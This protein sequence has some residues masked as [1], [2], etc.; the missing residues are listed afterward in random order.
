MLCC[1]MF[2]GS[3]PF[4][5][6]FCDI[7]LALFYSCLKGI[8]LQTL[9][10]KAIPKEKCRFLRWTGC[11]VFVLRNCLFAKSLVYSRELPLFGTEVFSLYSTCTGLASFS[12]TFVYSFQSAE[13]NERE[14]KCTLTFIEC[15]Q[16]SPYLHRV[17]YLILIIQRGKYI[18]ILQVRE[19]KL[20]GIL[21]PFNFLSK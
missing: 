9:C 13:E 7:D 8:E 5:S 12:L 19:L 11:I 15:L 3:L 4:S 6:D 2:P 16:Y 1:C 14:K 10:L 21:G 17:F 18:V 20:K